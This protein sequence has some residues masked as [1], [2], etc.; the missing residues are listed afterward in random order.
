MEK[1]K[2]LRFT[3]QLACWQHGSGCA[4][5]WAHL[6]SWVLALTLRELGGRRHPP[7]QEHSQSRESYSTPIIAIRR[8]AT[9]AVVALSCHEAAA[10]HAFSSLVFGLQF[11][12]IIVS[13]A[14]RISAQHSCR[15]LLRV[16]FSWHSGP[17]YTRK[18]CT[19]ALETWKVKV[20]WRKVDGN[21]VFYFYIYDVRV[22]IKPKY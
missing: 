8:K 3:L 20:Q 9:Q 2:E 22:N 19:I 14:N 5:P 11:G 16:F 10:S 12:S 4:C 18:W 21:V 6:H 13:H 1:K 15:L 7:R 17:R